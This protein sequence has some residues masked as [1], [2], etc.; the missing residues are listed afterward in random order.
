MTA[1]RAVFTRAAAIDPSIYA[2][3]SWMHSW[4]W[5]WLP[6]ELRTEKCARQA[7]KANCA[8]SSDVSSGGG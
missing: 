3:T 7:F 2:V 4:D 6:Y 8:M 5:R 1:M